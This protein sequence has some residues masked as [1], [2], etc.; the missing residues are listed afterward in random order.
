MFDIPEH[1]VVECHLRGYDHNAFATASAVR[2]AH[3]PSDLNT[4]KMRGPRSLVVAWI[5]P[6]AFAQSRKSHPARPST[7]QI[8][9]A[10]N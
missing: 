1:M 7:Q 8:I 10:L 9:D 5:F 3:A 2:P 4:T 6:L